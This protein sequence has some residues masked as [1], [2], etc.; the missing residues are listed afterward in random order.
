M[1]VRRRLLARA[2]ATHAAIAAGAANSHAGQTA[3]APDLLANRLS[4]PAPAQPGWIVAVDNWQ[5]LEGGASLARI[6]Q[7]T[8]GIYGGGELDAGAGWLARAWKS[9]YPAQPS[10]AW[11]TAANMAAAI[12][13]T[14]A[15]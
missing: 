8:T 7:R 10:S 15:R 3:P 1:A 13:S 11:P 12:A 4:S 14:Q 6:K 2:F 5:T 9:P